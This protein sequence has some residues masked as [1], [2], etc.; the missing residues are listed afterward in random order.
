MTNI[1]LVV[2]AYF[3]YAFTFS[4]YTLRT[5]DFYLY[6]YFSIFKLLY[7]LLSSYI[8]SIPTI[9]TVLVFFFCTFVYILL[10]NLIGMI[11]YSYA[12]HIHIF[13]TLCISYV[14]LTFIVSIGVCLY[15]DFFLDIVN[16]AGVPFLIVPLLIA[17]E[18]ISYISRVLSISL[19]LFANIFAGHI[20]IH[21]FYNAAS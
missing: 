5:S 17:I 15:S 19:R 13:S 1:T 18:L 16:P 11:P 12:L 8:K 7:T 3:F 6:V 21:V 14:L 10:F 20:L 4:Y 2:F 9:Q